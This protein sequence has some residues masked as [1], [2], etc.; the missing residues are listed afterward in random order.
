MTEKPIGGHPS[1]NESSHSIRYFYVFT[2]NLKYESSEPG[3]GSNKTERIKATKVIQLDF[4]L[5]LKIFILLHLL[6]FYHISTR[7]QYS[8]PQVQPVPPVQ[9]VHFELAQS[10][11]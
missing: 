1:H 9:P 11:F 3:C 4:P 8:I 7:W 10:W 6:L 2:N 5:S